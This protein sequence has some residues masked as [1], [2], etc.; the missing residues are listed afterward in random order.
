M[1]CDS[2]SLSSLLIIQDIQKKLYEERKKLGE[3]DIQLP[4][5]PISEILDS[6]TKSLLAV[7]NCKGYIMSNQIISS[8]IAQ[9]SEEK[10]INIVLREI[11]TADG[12][13]TYIR[14][15]SRFVDLKKE[16]EMSFWDISLRARQLREVVIGFKPEKMDFKQA[17]HL[18]INPPDKSVKR[19]W[20]PGD[21]IVT[22]GMD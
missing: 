13:E 11:L 6:R 17:A 8:V 20:A 9:V 19:K 22:F 16:S 5:S 12:S 4:C 21:M 15:V 14:S 2:R 7:A 3:Q 10:D 18:I 1:S